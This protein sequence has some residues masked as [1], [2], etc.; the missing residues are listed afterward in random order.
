MYNQ[1]LSIENPYVDYLNIA[2][3]LP[4]VFYTSYIVYI[5]K[6]QIHAYIVAE[7]SPGQVL[8]LE[9]PAWAWKLDQMTQIKVISSALTCHSVAKENHYFSVNSGLMS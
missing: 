5:V 7:Y 1:Y 9:D 6:T 3:K 8:A 2:H 4:M